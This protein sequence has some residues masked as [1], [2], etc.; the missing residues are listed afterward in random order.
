MFL[1]RNKQNELLKGQHQDCEK[2]YEK[3]Y[4]SLR[5][6]D[7]NGKLNVDIHSS[8]PIHP[9]V[10]IINRVMAERQG[11]I[12]L[13]L[14]EL[15]K[16]VQDLTSMTSI[17]EML[18]QLNEQTIQLAN[19]SEQAEQ[20]GA[21]ANEVAESS[22]NSSEFVEHATRAA[23]S[24]GEKIEQAIQFVEQ[25]FDEFGMVS[26]KVQEV[27]SSMEEIEQIVGV[28]SG[29]A[30]QTNLLALNAAI[31]AARAAEH[32]RGFAVVA[33]EV[34]KLAEYTKGS[35]SDISRKISALSNNSIETTNKIQAL[36]Q[37]M[38]RGKAVMQ[39]SAESMQ[40]IIQSFNAVT[41]DIHSIAAGSEEQS[42][43][44]EESSRSITGTSK[45]S[46]EINQI[47]KK[48][49]QGIYNISKSLQKIRLQEIKRIPE[50]DTNQALELCKTD[51][52]LWTWRIYN[53]ILGFENIK[54]SEVGD[55]HECRLGKWV[56]SLDAQK[57]SNL[58]SLKRLESPHE[59]VHSLARQAA[60]EYE[61]GNMEK[62]EQILVEMTQASEEVVA[63]LNQLQNECK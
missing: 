36:S 52:L 24:S 62:A 34:R 12:K 20:L 60:I 4:Q 41:Q 28:I 14:E 18:M 40:S 35:V 47:A 6:Y 38:Q 7:F 5:E 55:H 51:H 39:E 11:A 44:I 53:M 17:R 27:L 3:F 21:A 42:A 31:E 2:D 23:A 45:A 8:S 16:T 15:D 43:S 61:K 48:T 50:L 9:I 46:E 22:T 49:G 54:A 25:S 58:S 30:D 56:D 13:S 57:L 63:L 59:K 33:D 19:L 29:V 37:T 10:E 32:G 1:F 26:Q